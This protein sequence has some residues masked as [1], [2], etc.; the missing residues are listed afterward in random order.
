MAD[1]NSSCL[2]TLRKMAWSVL[3]LSFISCVARND[4]D[5][6]TGLICVIMLNRFYDKENA[7]KNAMLAVLVASLCVNAVTLIM[8]GSYAV[9]EGTKYWNDTKWVRVVGM[10]ASGCVVALELIVVL[11]VPAFSLTTGWTTALLTSA[12]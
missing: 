9:G 6:I 3:G 1:N 7:F 2:K 4:I 12:T 11:L 5:V 8:Y 10:V